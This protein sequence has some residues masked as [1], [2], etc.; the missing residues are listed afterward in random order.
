MFVYFVGEAKGIELLTKRSDEFH[1]RARKNLT[2]RIVWIAE[3]D[4]SRPVIESGAQLF[5]V[6]TPVRTTQ[7]HIPRRGIGQDRVRRIVFIKWFKDNDFFAGI[8]RS[9]H[10]GDHALGRTASDGDLGFR[11]DIETEVP[12]G[13]ACDRFTKIARAPGDCVL[14]E[15]VGYRLHRDLLDVMRRGKIRKA[16]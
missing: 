7:R 6:K 8:D 10:G 15:I 5:F 4:G 1:F 13:L 14:V 3:D 2:R 11:I 9:H 16:L 12:F